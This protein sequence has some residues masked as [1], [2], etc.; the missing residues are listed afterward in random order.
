MKKLFKLIF[1]VIALAMVTS[2]D[3]A[4]QAQGAYNM[5][6]CKYDFQSLTNLSVAGINPSNMSLMDAPK[7]IGLLSG[8]AT[9]IPVACTV[10]LG[11]QNPNSTEA[12]FNGLEYVLAIDGIDFTAGSVSQQLSVMPGQT[13]TLPLT[14]AFDVA[15]LLK[16]ESREA[17]AGIVK[18]LIGM[19]GDPSKVTLNIR[20][21]FDV[22]GYKVTS[23]VMIPVSFSFGGK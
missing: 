7:I 15:T 12:S 16:G 5:V 18:N 3:L 10:N 22:S 4:R 1:A 8:S 23:P 2:C 6:N 20:P 21:S 13:G 9:S 11:V 17:V 14:M 19:G